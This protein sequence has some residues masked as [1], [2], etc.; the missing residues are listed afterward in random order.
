MKSQH[1]DPTQSKEAGFTLLELLISMTLLVFLMVLVF[2]GLRF[3]SHAWANSEARSSGTDDVRL[4]QTFLR[5]SLELA[6]PQFVASDPTSAHIDFSGTDSQIAFLG[7]GAASTGIG[8]RAR[9]RIG[10]SGQRGTLELIVAESPELAS[11]DFES[12]AEVLLSGLKSFSISYFGATRPNEPAEWRSRW[13]N[14]T[15]LPQLIRIT[16]EFPERDARVWPD[17]VIAPRISADVG[18]LFDVL[19]RY[20]R[21]R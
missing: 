8:S 5:H 15:R 20:C 12:D 9:T 21:G 3:G 10:T 19:T 7:P 6:Y 4:A 2:G 16:A 11:A 17:L 14:Q 1:R 13:E 18:C